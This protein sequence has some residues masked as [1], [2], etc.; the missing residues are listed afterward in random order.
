MV[1]YVA[2][3][4]AGL[5]G[6]REGMGDRSKDSCLICTELDSGLEPSHRLEREDGSVVRGAAERERGRRGSG[7]RGGPLARPTSSH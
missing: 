1:P 6:E 2:G 3:E 4:G 7:E 5:S